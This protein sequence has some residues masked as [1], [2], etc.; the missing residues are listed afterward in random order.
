MLVDYTNTA[1]VEF[2]VDSTVKFQGWWIYRYLHALWLN[3]YEG[4][5]QIAEESLN[6]KFGKK[7]SHPFNLLASDWFFNNVMK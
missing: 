4:R 3:G 2:I 5:G 6:A 7:I 1:N